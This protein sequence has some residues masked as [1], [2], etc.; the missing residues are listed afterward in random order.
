MGDFTI[1]EVHCAPPP[2]TAPPLLT[3]PDELMMEPCCA[4]KYYP[5]V[6]VC[7]NEKVV[8]VLVLVLVYPAPLQDGDVETK[9]RAVVQ[10]EEEDF[11][12]TKRG[13]V[14]GWLGLVAVGG[15]DHW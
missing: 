10:A 13:L 3:S 2:P 6:D 12:N 4:L 5:A 9:K 15:G 11:G 14:G 7:Q 8:L 1:G